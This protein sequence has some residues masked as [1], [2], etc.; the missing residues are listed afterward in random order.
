MIEI[1]KKQWLE[2]NT[3][4][5]NLFPIIEIF[6]DDYAGR[7]LKKLSTVPVTIAG[8]G[9]Y[10]PLI[11]KIGS[12]QDS[13][14]I[15]KK[16]FNVS[17]FKFSVRKSEYLFSGYNHFDL[18]NSPITVKY[19]TSGTAES[20]ELI[21]VFKGII[22]KVTYSKDVLNI[23]CEDDLEKVVGKNV[24][25]NDMPSSIFIDEEYRGKPIPMIY[26]EVFTRLYQMD[27]KFIADTRNLIP[28]ST[29]ENVGGFEGELGTIYPVYVKKSG[30]LHSAHNT[31]WTINDQQNIV[32]LSETMMLTDLS[33]WAV[34]QIGKTSNLGFSGGTM[35][36]VNLLTGYRHLVYDDS[37]ATYAPFAMADSIYGVEVSDNYGPNLVASLGFGSLNTFAFVS[38]RDF[39]ING[40]HFDEGQ[41]SDGFG[42]STLGYRDIRDN[43]D[44]A[45]VFALGT[46]AGEDGG[47]SSSDIHL[48]GG[49][50]TS[51]EITDGGINFYA[52][53]GDVGAAPTVAWSIGGSNP[54]YYG[55]LRD[56]E[57]A[58]HG[59]INLTEEL[60]DNPLPLYLHTKGRTAL[61]DPATICKSILI[62]EL[63]LDPDLID[64]ATFQ[65]ALTSQSLF[66]LGT[67]VTKKIEARKLIT[68]LMEHSMLYLSISGTGKIRFNAL[69]FSHLFEDSQAEIASKDV[70][71]VK[72]KQTKRDDIYTEVDVKYN[73]IDD[74]FQKTV[75]SHTG[76]NLTFPMSEAFYSLQTQKKLTFEANHIS[77]DSAANTLR[78]YLLNHYKYRRLIIEAE[79]AL[80]SGLILEVGDIVSITKPLSND[81]PLGHKYWEL[82]SRHGTYFYPLF[83]VTKTNKFL[84]SVK[85]ELVQLH[86][87]DPSFTYSD[88]EEWIESWSDFT[89][90]EISP[91]FITNTLTP[92]E[93]EEFDDADD[94]SGG[95]II[96]GCTSEF[97]DE[98]NPAINYDPMATVD[99]G[100]CVFGEIVLGCT[101]EEASN[102]N[103]N[104]TAGNPDALVC[105]YIF[106]GCTDSDAINYDSE[107]TEDDGSCVY[108]EADIVEGCTDESASNYNP[109]ANLDDGSCYILGCTDAAAD[110]YN[111]DA[112]A[113]NPD[114]NDCTYPPVL[115]EGCLDPYASN[116]DPDAE[117]PANYLCNYDWVEIVS[118]MDEFY[119]V[120]GI[121]PFTYDPLYAL[122][123]GEH[124]NSVSAETFYGGGEENEIV[125][126]SF[127]DPTRDKIDPMEIFGPYIFQATDDQI[128]DQSWRNKWEQIIIMSKYTDIDGM[129]MD[130]GYPGSGTPYIS[131]G[132]WVYN[133]EGPFTITPHVPIPATSLGNGLVS[134]QHLQ[135]S[136]DCK[137]YDTFHTSLS[138]D[139]YNGAMLVAEW[140]DGQW[141]VPQGEEEAGPIWYEPS[142]YQPAYQ[143]HN[144][145]SYLNLDHDLIA[146]SA[147]GSFNLFNYSTA[148]DI[149]S[150]SLP[151]F[152]F[153]EQSQMYFR[154]HGSAGI[155][156]D[157]WYCVILYPDVCQMGWFRNRST[158]TTII[159]HG[160]VPASWLL[161]ASSPSGLNNILT[162]FKVNNRLLIEPSDD[163]IEADSDEAKEGRRLNEIKKDIR[164]R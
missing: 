3:P 63:N 155:P 109:A 35:S 32:Q 71:S 66:Q 149:P 56:I 108:D 143:Y 147:A 88:Q 134:W 132:E 144:Y 70:L 105:E 158:Q 154:T 5:T 93:Y 91:F 13:V 99:D 59:T 142:Q 9:S 64:D 115:T 100:S 103:P 7:M 127:Y 51:I 69:K 161:P 117:L 111:P 85:V 97:D 159:M 124:I 28:V 129:V 57:I 12:V 148:N 77:K 11:T 47:Y 80:Q 114:W 39:K 96:Y 14:D 102:Y 146:V 164:K 131:G 86:H 36:S 87:L 46:M 6:T 27:D 126:M 160:K 29:Q 95:L 84:E 139:N 130:Y 16:T 116:E 67:S 44:Q 48:F 62:D 79:L 128:E 72:Y 120:D 141:Y 133:E 23:T 113:G 30:I 75:A 37:L 104:A 33:I 137:I 15:N 17:N 138:S 81:V 83:M 1:S 162:H 53:W 50:F 40:V 8:L 135:P 76:F 112:T 125:V 152:G 34:T 55:K 151:V 2:L 82:S 20:W 49:D 94:G 136:S 122:E 24:P 65:T 101:D 98:G 10:H 54:T 31:Q 110:N 163:I 22:T 92:V 61:R 58:N 52:H 38:M 121:N 107:A 78:E 19:A 26:G 21:P 89:G 119:G 60:A 4:D 145:W 150:P 90:E 42:N 25:V 41:Y 156:S 140:R 157:S 18:E 123:M 106:P 68:E 45:A 153:Q 118:S 73:M 74:K 43:P